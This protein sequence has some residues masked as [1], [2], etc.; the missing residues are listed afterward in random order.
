MIRHIFVFGVLIPT[1]ITIVLFLGFLLCWFRYNIFERLFNRQNRPRRFKNSFSVHSVNS[2]Q[3]IVQFNREEEYDNEKN[4]DLCGKREEFEEKCEQC[5]CELTDEIGEV[6]DF[7]LEDVMD[8]ELFKEIIFDSDDCDIHCNNLRNEM[9]R[10][11]CS[12]TCDKKENVQRSRYIKSLLDTPGESCLQTER[13]EMSEPFS[14]ESK[15][16]EQGGDHSF[17]LLG[18]SSNMKV[19]VEM[20]TVSEVSRPVKPESSSNLSTGL[21]HV[22]RYHKEAFR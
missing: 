5:D 13:S 14:E 17:H 3:R 11:N 22:K 6:T 12:C 9:K 21:S 7:I 8:D 16:L 1:I 4:D 19:S 2:S 20:G 15:D 10:H 18:R